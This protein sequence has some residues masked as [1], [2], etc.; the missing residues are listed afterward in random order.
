MVIPIFQR[1]HNLPESRHVLT[2]AYLNHTKKK[3]KETQYTDML[4]TNE[5]QQTISKLPEI[6][7]EQQRPENQKASEMTLSGK[8]LIMCFCGFSAE[9]CYLCQYTV[10]LVNDLQP[11]CI[12]DDTGFDR[13][14]VSVDSSSMMKYSS[15]VFVRITKT[16]FIHRGLTYQSTGS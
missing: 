14:L 11:N 4:Y 16:C 13:R 6:Q 7:T 9:A 5:V 2:S 8:Q 15:N 1:K 10:D 12:K 3:K